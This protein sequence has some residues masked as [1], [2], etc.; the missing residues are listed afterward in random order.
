L[1]DRVLSVFLGM[2][3]EQWMGLSPTIAFHDACKDLRAKLDP[4]DRDEHKRLEKAVQ[5]VD[6]HLAGSPDLGG[7]GIAIFAWSETDTLI[8]TRLPFRP[9]DHV[10]WAQRPAIE[11]LEE[12]VDDYERFAVLL[13]DKERSR[14]LTIFLGEIED[15]Q[16][17]VDEVPGKQATGGWFGLSQKN[18]ARHHEDRVTKHAKRTNLAVSEAL[19]RRPFDRL[20]VAGPD[21][22][23]ALLL[24]HLPRP[25]RSRL[26]GRLKLELFA[27]DTDVL[28]A[29]LAAAEEL[30]R[31]EEVEAVRDLIDGATTPHVELGIEPT[32]AALALGRVH[33]LFAA[34]DLALDGSRCQRCGRLTTGGGPCPSCGGS[35]EPAADLREQAVEQAINQRARIE[36]VSGEAA[37][38]L[39][40]HGGLGARVRF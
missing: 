40:A 9:A 12:A 32:L 7:R 21:E 28:T 37:A 16:E 5:R 24:D 34:A 8:S 1:G 33:R 19:R 15:R 13:F 31:R 3:S 38:A 27:S 17:F 18:Y 11:P 39:M 36:I 30:E 23:V 26:A 22:A 2:T 25:L 6:D 35:T 10:V 20:F 4:A 29:A 14:F